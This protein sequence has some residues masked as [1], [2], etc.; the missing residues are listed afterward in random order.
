MH[1]P[2]KAHT[3]ARARVAKENERAC[4]DVQK[5]SRQ[6]ACARKGERQTTRAD[7]SKE[8]WPEPREIQAAG[9]NALLQE[10]RGKGKIRSHAQM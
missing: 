6:S 4:E 7:G 5:R 3:H 2:S 1:A 9:L 10:T 8:T